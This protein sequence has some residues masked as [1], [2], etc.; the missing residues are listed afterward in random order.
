MQGLHCSQF[1]SCGLSF[2]AFKNL[3]FQVLRVWLQVFWFNLCC[4]EA[5]FGSLD[6]SRNRTVWCSDTTLRGKEPHK[7]NASRPTISWVNWQKWIQEHVSPHGQ[8]M[9]KPPLHPVRGWTAWG[10]DGTPGWQRRSR[11]TAVVI[12]RLTVIPT[13]DAHWENFDV[14]LVESCNTFHIFWSRPC[15]LFL[16]GTFLITFLPS[17][18]SFPWAEFSASTIIAAHRAI[19]EGFVGFVERFSGSSL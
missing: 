2:P 3:G 1:Q 9:P 8:N 13:C 18:Y 15:G 5:P 19:S 11:K 12:D 14:R 16:G 17:W 10:W 7:G 6:S 4:W